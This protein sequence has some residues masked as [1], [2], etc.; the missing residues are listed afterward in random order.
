MEVHFRFRFAMP[1]FRQKALSLTLADNGVGITSDILP[2]VFDAF[3]TTRAT[4]G[5]GIGLFVAKQFVEG[6]GGRI[7]IDSS[8]ATGATWNVGSGLYLRRLSM[9]LLGPS[10]GST[11]NAEPLN[12]W[13]KVEM[14]PSSR[15]NSGQLANTLVQL[16]AAESH[17]PDHNGGVDVATDWRPQR[18]AR[19][20]SNLV[21]ILKVKGRNWR[22]NR[23]TPLPTPPGG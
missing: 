4:V 1:P 15:R 22:G 7:T 6:H 19:P 23:Q 16:M 2:R 13:H 11:V 12:L 21:G 18:H 14:F 20:D 8:I 5:T 17:V 10:I 9:R 3:F